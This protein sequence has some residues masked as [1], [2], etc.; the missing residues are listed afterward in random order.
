VAVKALELDKEDLFVCRDAALT[1]D[2]AANLALQYRL[3][4]I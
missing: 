2:L 1:D 3:K 4:T